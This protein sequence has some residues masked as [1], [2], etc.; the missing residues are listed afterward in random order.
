MTET[1]TNKNLFG[2]ISSGQLAEL[3]KAITGLDNQDLQRLNNLIRDPELFSTEI[4]E[5]LPFSIRKMMERGDL[6][7]EQLRK[8][9]EQVLHQSVKT[10]PGIMANILFPIMMPAIRKAVAEDIKRMVDSLNTSLEHGFSPKRIGW[11]FQAL[12]SGKKYAE[13]VLSNAYVFKVSQVFLIHRP[14]GLLLNQVQEA[15][16]KNARDADMVSSMLSA[17][18]DFVQDSF[19][20]DTEEQL[21]SI[22]VGDFNIWIEQGPYA[23]IAAIVEG[24]AP[25]NMRVILQEAVEAIHVNFSYEL[26]HFQGDTDAFAS[27]D[28][29]LQTCLLKE[30]KEEKKKKPIIVILLLIVLLGALGY[31]TYNKIETKM[32][33]NRLVNELDRMAGVIITDTEKKSGVYHIK[34]LYD[35]VIGNLNPY[36]SKYGFDS[37]EINYNLESFISIDY[38]VLLLRANRLLLPPETIDL[39]LRPDTLAATGTATLEWINRA[40][41]MA[42]R[43]IGVSYFDVSGINKQLPKV[44]TVD[45]L[46]YQVVKKTILAI[47]NYYFIFGYNEARLDSLQKNDF[48]ILISE[49]QSILNFSFSQDSVPVIEVYS[50]TS[51]NGRAD[52]NKNKAQQRAEEFVALMLE[53]GL[54]IETLVPKVI[55]VEDEKVPFPVRSVS[56]KVKYVNPASL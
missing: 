15:E 1:D 55:F 36:I 43:L 19:H 38:E 33:F 45:M 17:I 3:R 6:D 5:L 50:H 20:R 26:E 14:S 44:D 53:A 2:S 31:W 47:E 4:S 28:R 27:K 22:K 25:G 56:F 16:L 41:I 46:K 30:K 49:V 52:A 23:I 21:D 39:Y 48:D 13:I 18:K 35:P 42:T 10:D 12:F 54:P 32:R 11:R 40:T 7:Q 51:L 34:G 29:F 37:Q 24:N 9:V 8:F